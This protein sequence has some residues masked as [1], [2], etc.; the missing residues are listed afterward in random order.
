MDRGG[1]ILQDP[2]EPPPTTQTIFTP[3]GSARASASFDPPVPA[4]DPEQ[5]PIA[6]DER[7]SGGSSTFTFSAGPAAGR[8]DFA[9]D[10]FGLSDTVEVWR[11]GLRIA[12]SGKAYLPGGGPVDAAVG[13]AGQNVLSFDYDPDAGPLEFR[14]IRVGPISTAPGPSGP[15]PWRPWAPPHP[16]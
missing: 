10:A 5:A 9:F 6:R 16:H 14:F 8:I 7:P 12:A 3:S 1:A 11:D 13:V 2:S 15:Y 4:V